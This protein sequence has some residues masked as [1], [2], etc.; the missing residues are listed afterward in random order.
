MGDHID[1]GR[2]G[3]SSQ[4]IC[5]LRPSHVNMRM[6]KQLRR[7]PPSGRSR[8]LTA[9]ASARGAPWCAAPV[10]RA[11]AFQAVAAGAIFVGMC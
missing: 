9:S 10:L 8:G 1:G 5:E 2:G 11:V 3:S 6:S 7:G 4:A